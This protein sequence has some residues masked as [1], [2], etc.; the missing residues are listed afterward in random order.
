VT[1][2]EAKAYLQQYR[3]SF[4]R[5]SEIAQN[6]DEL[7]AEAVKLKDH[8]GQRI[9]LDAAVAKYMDA[10]ESA[11][12]DLD[13]LNFKRR[14]IVGTIDAIQDHRLQKLLREVYING[15]KLVRY[16]ADLDQSYEHI[17]RL[18]GEALRAVCEVLRKT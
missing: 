6:L 13:C 1:P 17:C 9:Q 11:S 4:D 10:C 15:I 8:T 2:K 18:H 16:A 12:H 7:K 14:E 3:E 5:T